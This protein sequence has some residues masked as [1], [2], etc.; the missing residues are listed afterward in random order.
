MFLLTVD[1]GQT[2]CEVLS[3]I[4]KCLLTEAST[5][6]FSFVDVI[7]EVQT[8]N[9]VKDLPHF[10]ENFVLELAFVTE[11]F[12]Y[13]VKCLLTVLRIHR[14]NGYN[15]SLHTF[16]LIL[17]LLIL[18][19]CIVESS[20]MLT[21]HF[22]IDVVKH[23]GYGDFALDVSEEWLRLLVVIGYDSIRWTG[24]L[25]TAGVLVY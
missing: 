4:E 8:L 18:C 19:H 7:F 9:L 16:C 17:K 15:R 21:I 25:L 10:L 24:T 1:F 20:A 2:L 6:V 12:H 11:A 5:S 23:L 3:P 14:D 22:V 13:V